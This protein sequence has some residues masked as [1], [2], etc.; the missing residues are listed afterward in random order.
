MYRFLCAGGDSNSQEVQYF[1]QILSLM[2]KPVPPP[3]RF[4]NSGFD[5]CSLFSYLYYM[6]KRK[7]SDSA[8]IKAVSESTSIRQVLIKLGLSPQGGSYNTVKSSIHRLDLNIDHFK[9]AGWNKGKST[10]KRDI[11]CYLSN[12]YPIKSHRLKLRL[13][14]EGYFEHKCYNCGLSNWLGEKMPIELEHIDGNN[15]NNNLSNLTIVCPNCHS[16]TDTYRGRKLKRAD[17]PRR[18]CPSCC[19]EKSSSGKICYLCRKK[20]HYKEPKKCLDCPKYVSFTSK[21]C[22]RC[23]ARDINKNPTKISWPATEELITRV[24]SS[25]YRQVARELGV[26]DNAIRKRIRNHP[27]LL[28]I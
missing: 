21:R 24:K 11:E 22:K 26:S 18:V 13:I 7:W 4:T 20:E 25:S 28:P 2:C 14:R 5:N 9:G 3:A 10:S 17:N 1:R 15:N 12:E 6:S 8:L 27:S 23:A 19:G 16:L